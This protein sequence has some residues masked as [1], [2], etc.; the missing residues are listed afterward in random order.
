MKLAVLRAYALQLE[1]AAKLEL[2]EVAQAL[3][4]TDV[5]LAALD[6]QADLGADRYVAQVQGGTTVGDL[7][8]RLDEMETMIAEKR[9]AEQARASLQGRW[10]SKRDEVLEASRYR[11]KLDILYERGIREQRRRSEQA[12]QRLI[13]DRTW[14]RTGV[15]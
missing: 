14:R 15:S 3:N 2:A 4:E 10:I 11:K 9:A 6:R 13:D 7:Y 8:A 12:D 1:Q 5:R